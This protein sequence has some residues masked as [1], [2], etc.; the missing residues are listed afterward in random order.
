LI[1]LF[2]LGIVV[3]GICR[4]MVWLF[5]SFLCADESFLLLGSLLLLWGFTSS[6]PSLSVA[7]SS[8]GS[9][10]PLVDVAEVVRGSWTTCASLHKFAWDVRR[11][12][13]SSSALQVVPSRAA[14]SVCLSKL[15]I[16]VGE[17]GSSV[18]PIADKGMLVWLVF[19][20][21]SGWTPREV[22]LLILPSFGGLLFDMIK[23]EDDP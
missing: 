23:D 20:V 6:S 3:V 1:V 15:E 7:M 22:S 21:E 2:I 11:C 5:I 16:R 4:Y 10:S 9:L 14:V 18:A 12:G 13:M 19:W 8:A 17:E